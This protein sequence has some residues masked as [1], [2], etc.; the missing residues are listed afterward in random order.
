MICG[1]PESVRGCPCRKVGVRERL[2]LQAKME[3][4]RPGSQV[5]AVTLHV[6][7][8]NCWG[9]KVFLSQVLLLGPGNHTDKWQINRRKGLFIYTW[10]PTKKVTGLLNS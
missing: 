7:T 9:G 1:G 4:L 10:E 8:R 2:A 6:M 3:S 5:L